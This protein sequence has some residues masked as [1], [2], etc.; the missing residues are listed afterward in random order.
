M[1][2]P[3]DPDATVVL[4]RAP[5]TRR[6][7]PWLALGGAFAAAALAAA[8]WLGEPTPAPPAQTAGVLPAPV[9]PRHAATEASPL[10]ILAHRAPALTIFRLA[11]NNAIFVLDFP[12]L[13]QQGRMLNR[14]AALVEKAGLPRD[15]VLDDAALAAAIEE[16]GETEETFYLGHNYR[17]SDL[18]RFFALA[19]SQG[20][21]LNDEE[22]RLAAILVDLG[23]AEPGPEG[24]LR[25]VTDAAIVTVPGLQA[26]A[27][28]APLAIDIDTRLAILRHELSHGEFF[29][30]NAYADHVRT[31]WQQRL[32]P[33]ERTQFR[34]FLSQGGYDPE[35]EEVMMN[36][37]MAYLMHTPD[38]RFFAADMVGLDDAGLERLRARFREGLPDTWLFRQ[39]WPP[40]ARPRR[41]RREA[42]RVRQR[43]AIS[44]IRTCVATRPAAPPCSAAPRAAR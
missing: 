30:N 36:E 21:A 35:N 12:S 13:S 18:G 17:A 27:A 28:G 10:A 25:G 22:R 1:R 3:V 2:P 29:T 11:E 6:R 38:P 40:P 39:D 37:A 43:S 7:V 23:I 34:R 31:W 44:T 5:P 24:M 15:R 4:R 16:R 32:G 42:G 41:R 33:R 9:A 26:A 8:V 19:A 20:I 14:V